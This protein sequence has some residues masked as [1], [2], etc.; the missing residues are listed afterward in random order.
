MKKRQLDHILMSQA[1]KKFPKISD[2]EAEEIVRN[3]RKSLLG[4]DAPGFDER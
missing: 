1:K 2:K 3:N 4:F